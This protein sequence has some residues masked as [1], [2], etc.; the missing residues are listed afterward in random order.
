[1]NL[2]K[3][4]QYYENITVTN[5]FSFSMDNDDETLIIFHAVVW[6]LK[7]YFNHSEKSAIE[8]VNC[9]YLKNKKRFEESGW[10]D[11][12][13]HYQGAYD[14]VLR[15]H[16]S[17]DLQLGIDLDHSFLEWKKNNQDAI[18]LGA[19]NHHVSMLYRVVSK[20]L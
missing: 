6:C 7:K 16:Y 13:Y 3:Y 15:I 4:L 8:A 9:Y 20:T 1:M 5:I 19:T 2:I 18:V 17:Q 11:D 10:G 14:M 12:I